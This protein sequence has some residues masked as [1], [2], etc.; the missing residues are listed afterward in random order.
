[1][2]PHHFWKYSEVALVKVEEVVG[3]TI[4]DFNSQRTTIK[5]DRIWVEINFQVYR[6]EE[7]E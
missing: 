1:M 2:R 3:A 6:A 5:K 7:I 4:L